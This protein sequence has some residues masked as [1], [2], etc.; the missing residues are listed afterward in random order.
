MTVAKRIIGLAVLVIAPLL[1]AQGPP[2]LSVGENTKLNAGGLLTFGYSGDYGDDISSNH[3]LNWGLDG[4]LSGYYYNPNFLSFTATPYYNQ[5]RADSSFQSLTAATGIDTTANL[6]TGSKFPGSVSYRFDRNSSGTLGLV[7]QPNFTTIG[8]SQGFSVNWSALLPDW[9]TLSVGYSQGGG[10]ANLYGTSEETHSSNKILNIHS[11]YLLAGF[12]LNAFYDHNSV[13][14]KYPEFLA[15][16]QDQIQDSSGQNIGVGAQHTLPFQGTFYANYT[17]SS[18]TSNYTG[19]GQDTNITSYTDN[20]ESAGASFHPVQ[21]LSLNMS[22]SYTSNLSGY[23]SQSLG[24]GQP[25]DLGSGSHSLTLG[26]GANYQIT[27]YLSSSAQATYY[28]QYYFGQSFTGT[29]VSGTL[30]YGKRLFDMF[31]FSATMLDSSNGHGQNALGF[32]GTLNYFH[33][34]KGWQTSGQFTYA[35]NVQ[36]L[37]VTYTTSYYNYSA[38]I[39][40]RFFSG[41]WHWSAGFNGARSGLTDL[42]GTSSHSE[43]FSTTLGSRWFTTQGMYSRSQGISLLNGGQLQGVPPQGGVEDFITFN[44]TSYSGS[45]SVTPLRRLVLSGSFSRGISNTLGQTL[46]HNDA[47]IYN[48]QLQYHLR[49]IGMQA[50]YTR[51]TQGISAAGAPA[52]TNAYFVGISRWFDFF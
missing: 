51:F 24:G 12:R 34:I 35:Q 14:S 36:T 4:K 17:R 33:R 1:V 31:T 41:Q 52:S 13:N 43:G 28:D 40:R 25:V 16:E 21:K 7:G 10:G 39:H 19:N 3:G 9:P 18:A 8:H 48:A 20:I 37:L 26:G 38:N 27:N 49:R 15:G 45:F 42:P 50:G 6:F 46:S 30:N 11:N 29:F 47:Q 32:M 22:E 5:S 2:A 23:I 44:G